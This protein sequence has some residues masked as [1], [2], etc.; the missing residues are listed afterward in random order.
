MHTSYLTRTTFVE[1]MWRHFRVKAKTVIFVEKMYVHF[2]EQIDTFT[3]SCPSLDIWFCNL[4]I[5][6]YSARSLGSLK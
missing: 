5:N 6:F 2:N 3:Q 1:K 4:L